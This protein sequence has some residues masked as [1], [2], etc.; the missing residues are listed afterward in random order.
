MKQNGNKNCDICLVPHDDDIHGATVRIRDWFR[1]E[2]VRQ[3]TPM[4]P[5][6]RVMRVDPDEED[7][8]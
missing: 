2:V 7:D 8:E 5:Y 1:E 3:T 4:S 6:V